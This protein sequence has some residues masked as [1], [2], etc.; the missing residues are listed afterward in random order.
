MSRPGLFLE[1]EE[2]QALIRKAHEER[3]YVVASAL[4]RAFAW[5]LRRPPAVAAPPP[6]RL[7]ERLQTLLAQRWALAEPERR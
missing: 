4:K 6:T 7:P 3:S 2:L 5:F 1:P